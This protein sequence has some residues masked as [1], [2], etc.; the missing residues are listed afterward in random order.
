MLRRIFGHRRE[1]VKWEEEK[2]RLRCLLICTTHP[3]FF[4]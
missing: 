1:E 2:Y 3:I 4:G